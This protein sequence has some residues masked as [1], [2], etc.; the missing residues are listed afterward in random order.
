MLHPQGFI[1]RRLARADD[2]GAV[3]VEFALVFTLFIV[4]VFGMVDFG[5]GINA[6]TQ[7]TNA[8]REGARLGTVTLDPIAVEDRVRESIASLDDSL[9][10]VTVACETPAGT[11]CSGS[12]PAGDLQNGTEGDSVVV[13][14]DYTYDLIT[15]LPGFTGIGPDLAL[16]SITVM[17]IE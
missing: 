7:I 14:V 10:V 13:T 17:R 6:K 9:V 12:F 1:R 8:G 5:L 15:P 2:E 4:L 16:Q 3:L 11:P